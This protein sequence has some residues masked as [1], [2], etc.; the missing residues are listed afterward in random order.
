MQGQGDRQDTCLQC[1]QR[2]S[3]ASKLCVH[4]VSCI[5]HISAL[6][7]TMLR[8]GD[9]AAA[10]WSSR[11]TLQASPEHGSSAIIYIFHSKHTDPCARLVT[12][13]WQAVRQQQLASGLGARAAAGCHARL[14]PRQPHRA[15]C[16]MLR[17][18]SR[19][20]ASESAKELDRIGAE[21]TQQA[22][23]P[24]CGL[25]KG[26]PHYNAQGHLKQTLPL[27]VFEVRLL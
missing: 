27:G 9:A 4:Q 17:R 1:A 15:L 20:A 3:A 19:E 7:L 6:W 13:V 23:D 24:V 16:D 5:T 14:K 12:C 21:A 10:R 25:L 8:S 18:D 26:E 22:G 11:L 2:C